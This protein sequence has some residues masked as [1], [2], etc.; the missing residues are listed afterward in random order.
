MP[1][2]RDTER[3]NESKFKKITKTGEKQLFLQ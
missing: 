3:K 1:N 2:T